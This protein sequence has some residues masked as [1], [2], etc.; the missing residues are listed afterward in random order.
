MADA[1]SVPADSVLVDQVPLD[2]SET[3]VLLQ[4]WQAADGS[5]YRIAK[6]PN[7]EPRVIAR[8]APG[9]EGRADELWIDGVAH[10]PGSAP[11]VCALYGKS[12]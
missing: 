6:L 1:P 4:D 3:L 9:N 8:W 12:A 7:K 5:Y 2:C 10:D 11:G